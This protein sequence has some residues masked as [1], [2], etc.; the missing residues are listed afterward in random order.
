MLAEPRPS[1]NPY[2]RLNA[3]EIAGNL[4][5]YRENRAFLSSIALTSSPVSSL[6]F[7]H[8]ERPER[9]STRRGSPMRSLTALSLPLALS[10]CAAVLGTKQK[11][12]SLNSAPPGADVYLNGNRLG[13]TPVRVKLSNQA[14]HTFVFKREGFKEATCTLNRGTGAGWVILDVLTGLVP[15]IIDAATGSWSQTK[16]EGCTQS[17][18]PLTAAEPALA[19][20]VQVPPQKPARRAVLVDDVPKGANW[21]ANARTRMYYRVGCPVTTSIP[22][23]DRLY[24]GSES[25][26][27]AAGFIRSEE[28]DATE[29]SPLPEPASPVTDAPPLRQPPTPPGTPAPALGPAPDP[30]PSPPAQQKHLRS[31]FW[32]NGGLGF[33]SLGC[34][35][36]NGREGALSGGL[37]LGGTLGQKVLLGVGSNG[38]RKSDA[39]ETLTAGTLTALIRFY[40]SATGGF[41]LLGGLGVGSI[42]LEVDGVGSATETGFGV[43]LGLGYDI[44]VGRTV[45][46]TPFWNGFAVEGS[47]LDA[48]V[49][50]LGL[51]L[52]IH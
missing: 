42:R 9:S 36:C 30:T 34:R 14:T 29:E 10:G 49:G 26:L 23:P 2:E 18:E 52:T 46:L 7:P 5:H 8:N 1:T 39:G 15:V 43:L 3:T 22:E 24:Y 17:L 28:C 31:G 19:A 41:F 37:A 4:S 6:L 27:E 13:Q 12:F 50:Q 32:F 11:D 45:S 38:W 25:S 40:P 20:R 35:D 33:G 16:G 48:N 47:D 21:I 44:R 51:G